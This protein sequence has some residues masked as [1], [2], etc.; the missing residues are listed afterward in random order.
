MLF[1]K[2]IGTSIIP[3]AFRMAV[4]LATD[5]DIGVCNGVYV[6]FLQVVFMELLK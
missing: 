3:V 6:R 1:S 2:V 5:T 4:A